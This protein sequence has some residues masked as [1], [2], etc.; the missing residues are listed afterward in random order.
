MNKTDLNDW[1]IC[2]PDLREDPL[3]QPYKLI[4]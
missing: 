1:N 2:N 3:P 4:N